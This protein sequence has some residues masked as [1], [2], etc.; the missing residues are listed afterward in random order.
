M[1]AYEYRQLISKQQK[2]SKYHA[3]KVNVDGVV[4]D[5]KKEANRGAILEQQAKFGII[6]GLERQVEFLLQPEYVNNQ[7]KK[8]RPI[9]YKADF[10]YQKAGQKY[11]EDVKGFKTPEYRLKK[12]LFEYKY[13]KYTFVES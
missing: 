9:T 8:I 1:N 13:P 3:K 4:Y 6:T 5:S 7:G 11:V 10:V 12:K 2:S